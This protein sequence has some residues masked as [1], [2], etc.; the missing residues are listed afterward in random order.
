MAEAPIHPPTPSRV[1]EA[2]AAGLAP[3]LSASGLF[4]AVLVLATL[5]AGLVP[6]LWRR[7]GG[8]VRI[9]LEAWI[10]G[11]ASQALPLAQT[12]AVAVARAVAS[13]LAAIGLCVAFG[14]WLAQGPVVRWPRRPRHTFRR[15]RVSRLPRLFFAL[16]LALLLGLCLVDA[17]WLRPSQLASLLSG[18]WTRVALL[19]A[20]LWVLDAALA[21]ERFFRALWLTRSEQRDEWREAYGAPE[22]RAARAEVRRAARDPGQR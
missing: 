20:G 1:A 5:Q 22:L 10:R 4:G 2:R 3:L 8:L 19:C 9:P 21:R 11:D 13:S 18:W 14:L 15:P 16:G 12:L 17:V 6:E 7:L